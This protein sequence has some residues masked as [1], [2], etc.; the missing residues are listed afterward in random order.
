MRIF[1]DISVSTVL[2]RQPGRIL[3]YFI[4]TVVLC[5]VLPVRRIACSHKKYTLLG[6]P[7]TS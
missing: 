6:A 4:Y 3:M 2:V 1:R 5:A 7:M